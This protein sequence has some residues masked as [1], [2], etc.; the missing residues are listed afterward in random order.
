VRVA[1]KWHLAGDSVGPVDAVNLCLG[2][3]PR[4]A[5]LYR[6]VTAFSDALDAPILSVE[7]TKRVY[8]PCEGQVVRLEATGGLGTLSTHFLNRSADIATESLLHDTRLLVVHSLFRGHAG[9]AMRWAA[10][11]RKHYWA[12]PHGCLD[13]WGM[14]QR[15]MQKRLWMAAIGRR[16][17]AHADRVIFASRREAEKAS[18]WT[19]G[20]RTAVV[21]FPVHL[22]DLGRQDTARKSLRDKLGLSE[23]LRILVYVGR[24]AGMKR[25][26]A[27]LQAFLR[28]EAESVA[29]VFVGADGDLTSAELERVIPP[30]AAGRI[31]FTGALHGDEL[32][33]A[34]LAAD[35][36]ISLSHRENFGFSLAEACAY[37]LPLIATPGHDLVHEMPTGG[38]AA[39]GVGWVLPDLSEAAAV[40]AMQAFAAASE[41]HLRCMGQN[42]RLWAADRLSPEVFRRR[43]AE[44]VP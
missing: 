18:D 37:G 42:A 25:P 6:G 40:Q 14:S 4:L 30:S 2:H 22:P 13:P 5:G 32:D 7:P 44:L 36:F 24:L 16:Y 28:A 19:R 1:T 35:G 21:H 27:L 3:D 20:A 39:G 26:Q 33:E 17:V 38:G 10:E 8:G 34:F 43:L 41:S 12:V 31:R 29:L 15:R 23:S 11:R 9:F